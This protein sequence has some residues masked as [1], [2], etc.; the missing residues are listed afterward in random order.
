MKSK[1][2]EKLISVTEAAGRLQRSERTVHRWISAGELKRRKLP[3]SRRTFVTVSS[4]EAAA[5]RRR[6]RRSRAQLESDLDLALKLVAALAEDVQRI[7]R[8]QQYLSRTWR[9]GTL[10]ILESTLESQL[11]RLTPTPCSPEPTAAR[12]SRREALERLH[13]ECFGGDEPE[14]AV[15]G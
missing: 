3:W 14:V 11:D 12:T 5:V 9:R 15:T 10:G 7:G 4:V 13:P 8:R 6:N 1:S 2:D